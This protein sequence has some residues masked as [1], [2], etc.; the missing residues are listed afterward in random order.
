MRFLMLILTLP[1]GQGGG[2]GGAESI[3]EIQSGLT[4]YLRALW[5]TNANNHSSNSII[6]RLRK[7]RSTC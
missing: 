6:R 4:L 5:A 3:E 7:T 1:L 2:S